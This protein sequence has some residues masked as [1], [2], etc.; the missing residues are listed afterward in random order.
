MVRFVFA[1]NIRVRDFFTIHMWQ[2]R[3]LH[4]DYNVLGVSLPNH[5]LILQ[6]VDGQR[7]AVKYF[8]Y[9]GTD[10]RSQEW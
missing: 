7:D 5:L 10:T 9:R 8:Y 6:S 4:V 1:R 3:V 2:A